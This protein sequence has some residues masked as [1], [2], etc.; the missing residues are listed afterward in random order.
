[1]HLQRSVVCQKCVM[2]RTKMLFAHAARAP[3]Q[4]HQALHCVQLHVH[5]NDAIIS[6][7]DDI[8]IVLHMGYRF[9]R[10]TQGL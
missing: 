5:V 2:I 8:M 1:M 7:V 4:L 6:S 9:S 10:S 3:A